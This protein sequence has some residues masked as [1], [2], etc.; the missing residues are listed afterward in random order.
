MPGARKILMVTR[1]FPPL[2]GGMEKLNLNIFLALNNKFKAYLAGP[3]GSFKFHKVFPYIEFPFKP[4][5]LYIAMSLFKVSLF[6]LKIKPN[7][8]FCGSGT[9]ILAGYI[10]ARLCSA[11]LICYLHG[12]DIVASSVV[13][14]SFFVPLIGKSNLVIV[15]SRHTRM[16]A[17]SAGIPAE[18]IHL[19]SPGVNLPDMSRRDEL[20]ISF[21]NSYGLGDRKFILIAGRITAR[22]GVVEFIEN[23]FV[24]M[25]AKNP[26]LILVVVGE[27]AQHAAKSSR[28]VTGAIY[29]AISNNGL[30]RNVVLTGGVSELSFSSALFSASAFVF[31]VLN[32]PNDVEGFGMVAIEAAA[33][34]LPTVG[35][36]VGG[37]PDA[38]ENGKSGWLVES[39][40]YSAMEEKISSCLNY[41]DSSV[42]PETCRLFAESFQWSAFEGKLEKIVNSIN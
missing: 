3:S 34:G 11:K 33:H 15:N 26:E 28:G 16:L 4:L 18:R 30:E 23:I 27:E 39:G 6:A 31:P 36:S 14:Q 5:W 29:E 17:I 13:Y 40:D 12:L 9:S 20:A 19:L 10:S 25:V 22:K 37:V 32:L 1:N 42:T 8:V 35:F 2:V 38:I 21:R 7:I 41:G 24:Q